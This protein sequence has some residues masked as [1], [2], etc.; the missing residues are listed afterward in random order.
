MVESLD[1]DWIVVVHDERDD[2]RSFERWC[3]F[4]GME[5]VGMEAEILFRDLS[6][7][8]GRVR[9]IDT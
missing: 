6:L 2:R 4:A 7:S 1:G 5:M 3:G 9:E 8:E